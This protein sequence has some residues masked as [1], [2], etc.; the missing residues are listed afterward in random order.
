MI[1]SIKTYLIAIVVIALFAFGAWVYHL[2]QENQRLQFDNDVKT[3]NEQA[4]KDSVN[5]LAG[6]VTTLTSFVANLNDENTKLKNENIAL[7]SNTEILIDSIKAIGEGHV[8]IRDSIITVEFD[9]SKSFV[10]YAGW[11]EYDLKAKSNRWSLG[12][13]FDPIEIKAELYED[14]ITQKWMYRTTSLTEGVKLKG[15]STLDEATFMRLQKYKP[16][17]LPKNFG[18]NLQTLAI[19]DFYVG[20]TTRFYQQYWFNINYKINNSA[21]KWQDNLMFGVHYFVF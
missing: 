2:Y 14:E 8:T 18:I 5:I 17:Q 7:K 4:Y 21:D 11:T 1:S 12:M 19:K 16:E 15:I 10:R 20:I 6:K 9:G 13:E 3:Q